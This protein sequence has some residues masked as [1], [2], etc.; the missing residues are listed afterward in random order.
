MSDSKYAE[1]S[2]KWQQ[3][4]EFFDRYGTD[5]VALEYRNAMKEIPFFKRYLYQLNFIALFFGFIYFF[6]LGLWR[7]NLALIAIG[8]IMGLVFNVAINIF[9]LDMSEQTFEQISRGVGF[10]LAYL[11]SMTANQ[12]YYLHKVKGSK[13]W[14][15]FEKSTV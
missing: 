11:Y 14:D 2:K 12:A 3:R 9:A 15:P 13:S 1:Y 6:I 4:F 5:P 8:I 7:K 10:G